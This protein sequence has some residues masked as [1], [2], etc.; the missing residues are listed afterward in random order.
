MCGFQSYAEVPVD[1]GDIVG[2][3]AVRHELWA[4]HLDRHTKKHSEELMSE[5]AGEA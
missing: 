4:K 5:M 2:I 1:A 3:Q